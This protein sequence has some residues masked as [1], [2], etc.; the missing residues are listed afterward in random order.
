MVQHLT[1][2][3]WA[4]CV[5][6]SMLLQSNSRVGAEGRGGG[7]IG[8]YQSCSRTK[9]FS[10]LHIREHVKIVLNFREAAPQKSY[11][12]YGRAIKREGVGEGRAIKEKIIFFK[13]FFYIVAI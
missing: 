1:D 7:G 5:V 8:D 12:L 10:E 4:C 9:K 6:L 3:G 11:S 2:W 13:L